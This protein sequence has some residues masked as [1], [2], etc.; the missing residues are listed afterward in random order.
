MRL[1]VEVHTLLFLSV[2]AVAGCSDGSAEMPT[3]LVA[4]VPATTPPS[5]LTF[6]IRG[7]P[8]EMVQGSS[9]WAAAEAV[10]AEWNLLE[11]ATTW[12]ST[13]TN[14]VAFA[15]PQHPATH[16]RTRTPGT[17]E[18]TARAWALGLTATTTVTVHPRPTQLTHADSAPVVI[19]NFRVGELTYREEPTFVPLATLRSR[20][21]GT[22]VL[23]EMEF[24][25]PGL[26]SMV[27]CATN[28]EISR[29]GVP[30][31]L[32]VESYGDWELEMSALGTRDPD[33]E[34]IL[35]IIVRDEASRTWLVE[36]KGPIEPL[37]L[38]TTYSSGDASPWSCASRATSP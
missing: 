30:R 29:S 4:P 26:S 8:S 11:S 19:S 20:S 31:A 3:G 38:P 24:I 1:S 27:P 12:Y 22:L 34:A 16:V 15:T 9:A 2:L 36:A 21:A 13:D 18:V 25:V 10:D 32:T 17:A 28:R 33:A 7:V 37:S 14:V 35:R 6:R 5:G 23:L